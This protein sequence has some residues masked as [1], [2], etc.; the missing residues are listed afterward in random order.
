MQIN[1][2]RSVKLLSLSL[3]LIAAG[4]SQT[5]KD[6][7]HTYDRPPQ[8]SADDNSFFGRFSN[9]S[10]SRSHSGQYATVWERL[11]SLYAL[12]EID[13][14]RVDREI[15]WYLQHPQSLVSLQQ[16]AEPYLHH[17]LDEIEAKQIPG[18]L[19][20]LPV[21]ESSFVPDAYSKSAASGL[22]QF[23]P[24]TGQ[25][26][27]LK[28]NSWYDGRRDVYAST[29]AATS[30]LKQL[31][32]NFNGDWLLALASYNYG[33]GNVRKCIERNEDMDLPTDYWSLDLPDETYHYVPKLLAVA[34]I[35]A[36]AERYHIPLRHIPNKPYFEVVDIKAPIDLSKA[37]QMANTPLS[38]FLRLNP[39]F[40]RWCTAPDGPHRLLIPV[41]NAPQFKKN[42]AE[43]P[44]YER[45][46]Y[47]KL[48]AEQEEQIIAESNYHKPEP[49]IIKP[50]E[51]RPS[52]AQNFASYRVKRGETLASIA[53]RNHTTVQN[54]RSTNHLSRNS[55]NYGSV[56]KIPSAAAN[57]SAKSLILAKS[58]HAS[59]SYHT[60]KKGDTFYNIA[61]RYAVSPKELASWNR[62]SLNSALTPG[63]KLMIKGREQQVAS[64]SNS[65]RLIRYTVRKGDTLTQLSRKF[66]I[67]VSDLRKSN[68]VAL[69]K[70]LQPGQTLKVLVDSSHS[71]I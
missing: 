26:F 7:L 3:S 12:P 16:R 59:E 48:V 18:E 60:V 67:S 22:W 1:S 51:G 45:V 66:N 25:E 37:A 46:N 38:E 71:T 10:P 35:F 41:K 15:N 20:L 62:V 33:K 11:L 27:G 53:Q 57:P 31:S 28:Q 13:N 5:S 61:R 64:S 65:L 50:A 2:N 55:V 29:K 17:I 23:I 68:A 43:I 36:N 32:E 19:A 58:S 42:L 69:S 30:Y 6:S 49:A 4:C 14:E 8:V 70:G 63:R 21:V 47:S 40:N 34:K 56:L 24:S 52:S 44:Y 39:G 54:L 9:R